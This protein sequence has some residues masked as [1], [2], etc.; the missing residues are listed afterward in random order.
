MAC[1]NHSTCKA[2]GARR[3]LRAAI[4]D[5][6]AVIIATGYGGFNPKGFG[7]VDETGTR[8]LVD[9]AVAAGVSKLVMC[10]SL[11]TNAPA[12]GQ[13]ENPNYKFLV[14]SGL[15]GLFDVDFATP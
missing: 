6:Q 14:R 8:N 7:D 1:L 12:M 4:G 15:V 2:A 5:A 10:S 3:P 9:A 11:L 13:A